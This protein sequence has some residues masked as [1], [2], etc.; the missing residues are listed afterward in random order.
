MLTLTD[1]KEV[2]AFWLA[3]GLAG[4]ICKYGGIAV[5]HV[6]IWIMSNILKHLSSSMRRYG[7]ARCLES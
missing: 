5:I 7:V 3:K 2:E 6:K 1:G 4:V